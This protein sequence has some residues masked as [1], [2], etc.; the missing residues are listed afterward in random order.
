ME[1]LAPNRFQLPGL[2]QTENDGSSGSIGEDG[3]LGRNEK[4]WRDSPFGGYGGHG[5]SGGAQETGI[6]T[7][8][9]ESEENL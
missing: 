1:I 3:K 9:S 7:D 2:R 6:G 4:A 5:S 8:V